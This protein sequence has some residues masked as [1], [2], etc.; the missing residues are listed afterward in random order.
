MIYFYTHLLFAYVFLWNHSI[1]NDMQFYREDL[2]FKIIDNTFYVSGFYSFCN[3][4]NIPIRKL[5]FYPFP[6]DSTYGAVDSILAINLTNEASEIITKIE[7]D[8]FSFK[9]EIPGYGIVKYKICYQQKLFQNSAE[10]IL[11]STKKWEKPL[12]TASYRL[13]TD[14]DL[15][16]VSF[17]YTPD[18]ISK[19]NGQKIYYWS[20][21]DFM[22]DKNMM[23]YFERI[24]K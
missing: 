2:T 3:T 21:K 18:S 11:N 1:I 13:I 7:K 22:P 10:Y 17:T 15:N 4:G 12:E 6:I 9:I 23:F 24:C 5:L 20:K 16:I 8:G 19:A 14:D